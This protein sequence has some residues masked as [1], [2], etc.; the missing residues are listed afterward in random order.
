[1]ATTTRTAAP[2]D[3]DRTICATCSRRSGCPELGAYCTSCSDF[4]PP[5]PRPRAYL[6]HLAEVPP[7]DDCAHYQLGW[8]QGEIQGAYRIAKLGLKQVPEDQKF[9][10]EHIMKE[11]E[12]YLTQH[13]PEGLKEADD[14]R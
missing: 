14:V 12:R 3:P 4:E 8:A 9:Y 13:W 7:E 10:L 6:S 1:M 11:A 2:L 5:D